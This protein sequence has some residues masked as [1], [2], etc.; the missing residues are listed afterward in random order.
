MIRFGAW[1][2]LLG[3]LA[4]QVLVLALLLL[5]GAENRRANRYLALA[6]LVV[7]GMMTPFVI[8]YAGAYDA[9]PWLTSAPLA[10]PLLLGPALYAHVVALTE[11]RAISWPHWFAG[12][13]QFA[14]Q[15]LLFPFPLATKHWWD[16]EVQQPYLSATVSIAVLLSMTAY[17][18]A[19]WR[20]LG[21]YQ[22]WLAGRRRDR[23][24]AARI[25][26]AVTL[27]AL[28]VAA[29]AAY[30]LFDLFVRPIN[31]FDLFAFYV[32]LG[33]TGL[34]LG[35]DGWRNARVAAPVVEPLAARD[36]H[37]QGGLWL[38]ELLA[39]GWWRDPDLDLAT[40][41]RHLGTNV[42]HLSRAL[43]EGHGGFAGTLG[44]IRSE[45]VAAALDDGSTRDL[46]TLAL[47]A[48]FGSK[49]SFNRAFRA[50]FGESPTAYRARCASNLQ[51]SSLPGGMRR[52]S[53]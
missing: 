5:R 23:R 20:A 32:A 18:V 39:S 33:L 43:N 12:G 48:G 35:I 45:A 16:L 25:R 4:V 13:A 24:P 52:L 26:F 10:V 38:G 22:A 3:V 11:G 21:R 17:A 2:T 47:D 14:Q 50:R 51:S 36:W 29:R 19:S 53:G 1:S 27:L 37:A 6:L 7:A 30:E 15:A 42:A 46:L 28:L 44:A 34:L 9:W 49:A 40:L 41:A 31:Y 8:G